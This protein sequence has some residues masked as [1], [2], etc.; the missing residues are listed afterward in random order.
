MSLPVFSTVKK[1]NTH[2]LTHNNKRA[3]I[4]G[5]CVCTAERLVWWCH[6]LLLVSCFVFEFSLSFLYFHECLCV[7]LCSEISL[8]L[9]F[10]WSPS[11]LNYIEHNFYGKTVLSTGSDIWPSSK[12]RIS[13]QDKQGPRTQKR[14][15]DQKSTPHL[16]LKWNFVSRAITLCALKYWKPS[17]GVYRNM[18]LKKKKKTKWGKNSYY[19][20]ATHLKDVLSIYTVWTDI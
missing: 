17:G 11:N 5:V 12:N 18:K 4:S 9:F 14:P 3:W 7:H 8:I 2:T 15:V 19:T 13:Y 6:P 10:F 20:A 16:T 1:T